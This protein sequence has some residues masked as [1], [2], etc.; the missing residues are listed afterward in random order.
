M[1]ADIRILST[2][3]TETLQSYIE[4]R[5]HCFLGPFRPT[6]GPRE[7][8]H[9]GRQ[10]L[11]GGANK[12]CQISVELL[13]TGKALLQQ[14]VDANLYAAIGRARAL[15]CSHPAISDNHFGYFN[16]ASFYLARSSL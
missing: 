12:S 10:W 1:D 14:A 15:R 13:P 11:R 4:R 8:P 9:H 3:L 5:L 2:D 16:T 7:S 6:N